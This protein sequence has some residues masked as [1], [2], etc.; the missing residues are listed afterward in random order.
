[1]DLAGWIG[2]WDPVWPKSDLL[3]WVGGGFSFWLLDTGG[4]PGAGPAGGPVSSGPIP[5]PFWGFGGGELLAFDVSAPAAPK[6][7][8]EVNLAT[9]SWWSF[10]RPFS[11][12][13]IVYLSHSASVFLPPGPNWAGDW[14][15]RSYLDV[16]DYADPLSPTI[17]PPVNI[18]G[19]LQGLSNAGE[20]LYTVGFHFTTNQVFD[21]TEWLDASAYDGVA[22]HFVASLALPDVW[23]HPVLAVGTNVFIG[24]P[25]YNNTN[26]NIVAHQLE[27]WTLLA[28]GM[29]SKSGS[30][31]LANPAS[32]LLGLGSLLAAQESDN[33]IDLFDDSAPATLKLIGSGQPPEC[34]WF[35]LNQADGT[36]DRGLWIPLGAYGV[37]QV[38]LR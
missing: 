9:N 18:P 3:V 27:T 29:F 35:D 15:Q 13:T 14:V 36:V 25:G 26:A 22:A 32:S 6:F 34:L 21:W 1:M 20:L 16:I 28:N 24:R 12:G 2:N 19:T 8:S 37:G 23:P 7:D 5:W 31:T 11:S 4:G 17:R 30:V 33:S 10:S 38:L